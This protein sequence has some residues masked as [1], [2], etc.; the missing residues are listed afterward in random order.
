MDAPRKQC[1]AVARVD[2]ALHGDHARGIDRHAITCAEVLEK[3]I[4]ESPRLITVGKV[5]PRV[6]LILRRDRRREAAGVDDARRSHHHADRG[7]EIEVAADLI[8]LHGVHDAVNL[9]LCID[10]VEELLTGA[11]L[12]IRNL[13]RIHR[14]LSELVDAGLAVVDVLGGR[15]VEDLVRLVRRHG[16]AAPSAHDARGR[17]TPGSQS[18]KEERRKALLDRGA[19]FALAEGG[20]RFIRRNKLSAGLVPEYLEDRVH[21]SLQSFLRP[22]VPAPVVRGP[23]RHQDAVTAKSKRA[24]PARSPAPRFLMSGKP[25]V[26]VTEAPF[27]RGQVAPSPVEASSRRL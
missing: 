4:I 15:D 27:Q 18:R 14:E 7:D 22:G 25:A 26:A 11:E 12:Q 21:T 13:I 8:V 3:G 6:E 24:V 23:V 10:E 20:L 9:D 17:D 16:G 19:H 2:A 1:E 5:R